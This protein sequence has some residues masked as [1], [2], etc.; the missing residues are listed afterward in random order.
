MMQLTN[1]IV[2]NSHNPRFTLQLIYL[3]KKDFIIVHTYYLFNYSGL[4]L[5]RL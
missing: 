1:I 3:Y 2:L 5:I 4:V